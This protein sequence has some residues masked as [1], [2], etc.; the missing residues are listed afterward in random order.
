M[1]NRDRKY[2]QERLERTIRQIEK[3]LVLSGESLDVS[4][5]SLNG[6]LREYWGHTGSNPADEAQMIEE[7]DRQRRVA[8]IAHSAC[9]RLEQMRESPY[10]GRIDFLEESVHS[11]PAEKIYIGISTLSDLE[12]GELLI[13]D[14]RSPVAGMFYDFEKGKAWYE[15]PGG[16]VNGQIV[17]KRQYKIAGGEIKYMFDADLKI[18]DE[19]LQSILSKSADAAMHTIVT[20]IQREQNRIIRDEKHRVLF[21]QGPAGSGKTSIALHRVAYVLYRER[22]AIS[23]RNVLILSPNRIF[24]DY[25]S[26]VLPEIGEE[27][28]RQLTFQD[29]MKRSVAQKPMAVEDRAE[30]LEYLLSAPA[31]TEFN[32]RVCNIAYKSSAAFEKLLDAYLHYLEEQLVSDYPAVEFEGKVIFSKEEWEKY[33]RDSLSYL[34]VVRRLRKIR[35]LIQIRMRPLVHQLREEKVKKIA[36]SGEEV[37]ATTIKALARVAARRE[38][39]VLTAQIERLTELN[40]LVAYRRM[41]KDRN[42]F[43]LIGSEQR[44]PE[45]WEDIRNQTI[46]LW[47]RG[48]I[49]YEDSF[50]YIYFQGV[51]EGFPVNQDIRQLVVDEAQ[52]YT[53][54]QY[55]ILKRIFPNSAWTVLGDP[56][57]MIYPYLKTADFD[58]AACIINAQNTLFVKLSRS[59]RSTR[60]IQAFCQALL[61]DGEPV[62]SIDRTG[63]KPRVV[64]LKDKRGMTNAL[65]D[66]AAGYAR[67]GWQSIAIICKTVREATALFAKVKQ[68]LS[69]HLIVSEENEFHSGVVVIPAYLAKGLEFDAVLVANADRSRY[70]RPEERNILYTVCTRALH[71]LDLFLAGAMTPFVGEMNSSLYRLEKHNNDKE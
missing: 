35:E 60:E 48:S 5:D 8:G 11:E 70:C 16:V 67:E 39:T 40:P 53:A 2:E 20:S 43:Q 1:D 46:R 59:Y 6:T 23:A 24:S 37:N 17:L 57:Q 4:Q 12:T 41:F 3:Q 68:W 9:E 27:N 13:Y 32:T 19:I 45:G 21:V 64:R 61:P 58:E 52:D 49:P 15:S 44:K 34:P 47:D 51:L 14:W 50:A 31:G 26:H 10:F 42:F 18:D 30:Q 56:A 29:L 28:V 63:P 7:V 69:A 65:A 33:Y 36:A 66:T 55:K 71:R 25:I 54:F 62:E 38:L 22:T